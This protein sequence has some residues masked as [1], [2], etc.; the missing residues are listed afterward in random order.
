[1]ITI[2][3]ASADLTPLG[4]AG[5]QY[6]RFKSLLK[7]GFCLLVELHRKGSLPAACA[8]G[9]FARMLQVLFKDFATK[10][11]LYFG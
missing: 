10:L 4:A 7:G 2:S 1:M 8:E 3:F 5:S 11:T 9:L 6:H